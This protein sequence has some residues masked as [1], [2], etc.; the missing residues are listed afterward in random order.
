MSRQSLSLD[1]L[2]TARLKRVG[3]LVGAISTI[4]C[5]LPLRI[6]AAPAATSTTLTVSSGS[7]RVASV[8]A[9]SVITLTATVKA[10]STALTTGQVNF[11]DAAAKRCT[12]IHLLGTAQLTK[13]GTAVMKFR[14]GLGSYSYEAEFLGTRSDAASTSSASA[15]VVTGKH[16]TATKMTA[17]G[18][19]DAIYTLA[20]TVTGSPAKSGVAAPTGKVSFVDASN[21]NAVLATAT[22]SPGTAGPQ[23]V[24]TQSP[25]AGD[26]PFTV[27]TGDFNGDGI[28]DL[29]VGDAN[30][31]TIV[32]LL[33]NGD[34]TF[35][36]APEITLAS[37]NY[38][39]FI[40]VGDFNGDGIP[41]LAIV[42]TGNLDGTFSYLAIL[43]GNGDGTFKVGATP[44]VGADAQS[45]TVGD[46]NGDGT[47][48]LAVTNY[49]NNNLTIL[50]GN[51]DGT[52]TAA[53]VNPVTGAN[54][55]FAAAGD[56]NGD[57]KLDLAVANSGGDTLT[58]L[59]GNG[60]GTFKTAASPATGSG[61]A[62][63][64]VADFNGDGILDLAVP[65]Y[66]G[67]TVTIL[68]G[69]GD[70]TFTTVGNP[71]AGSGPAYIAAGDFNGDGIPDL[72]VANVNGNTA[73]IFLGKGDGTFPTTMT[74]KTGNGPD[75]LA[76]ADFN[77]DGLS[78][79]AIANFNSASLSIF[80]Q[81][82]EPSTA[83]ASGVSV[84]GHGTFQIE[85]S[86]GGDG[87]YGS[88]VSGSTTLFD[89]P[90]ATVTTLTANASGTEVKEVNA[91]TAVTLIAAVK[92]G[93]NRVA[94]GQV[95][96]CDASAPYCTDIHL[97]GVAPLTGA[98]T[99]SMT[100]VPGIG[101]HSYKAVFAGIT[102]DLAA[103]ASSAWP[104]T[105][106]GKFATKT[107]FAK[108][109][110]AGNYTLTAFVNGFADAAGAASPT[111]TVRFLDTTNN[112]ALLG[113]ATLAAGSSALGF[114]SPNPV[115]LGYRPNAIAVADFN[116]DG[117]LDAVVGDWSTL[118]SP[119]LT[120][121]L[122]N[123]DGTF[124]PVQQTV[125]I[126]SYA[127]SIVAGDF[128]GDGI[129]DLAVADGI[130]SITIL[131]GNGNGTFT[132]VAS[133]S[134]GVNPLSIVAADF[135]GDG[136]LDLA[137]ANAGDEGDPASFTV[138]LGNGDGT[139]HAQTY[140]VSDISPLYLAV[141]DFN[142]DG[143]PDLVFTGSNSTYVVDLLGKGDGTFPSGYLIETGEVPL[144]IAVAD[145]NQDGKPDL[146]VG[147]S[148]NQNNGTPGNV[149]IFLGYGDGTFTAA[150]SSPAAGVVY[151]A[152][153][154]FNGDGIP[155]LAALEQSNGSTV[156]VLLGKGDGTFT[157]APSPAS[158]SPLAYQLAVG[159]FN[160]DG[161]PDVALADYA[162]DTL[163]TFLTQLKHISTAKITGVALE[164]PV[165]HVVEAS[166]GGDSVFN[167]SISGTAALPPL[168]PTPVFSLPAGVYTST[169]KV[170]LS[171]SVA[172][173]AFYYTTDGKTNPTTASKKYSA[174]FTVASTE[175]IKAIAV[176]PGY[177]ESAVATAAYEINPPAAEPAFQ[178]AGATYTTVQSVK[179]SDATPGVTIYYTTN[180]VTIP[181]SSTGIK[182]T[183]PIAVDVSETIMAMAMG[184]DN[185]AS[186]VSKATYTLN[187]PPAAKPA[188]KPGTGTYTS[189]Q[190]VSLSDATSG[191]V[192][193]YTT[194]GKTAPSATTGF[195]YTGPIPVSGTETILATA[196]GTG[197]SQSPVAS[198]TYTIPAADQA[199]TIQFVSPIST[200][201]TQTIAIVGSGF[202]KQPAFSGNSPDINFVD[203][204]SWSAGTGGDLIGLSISSWTE[205]QI[206]ISGFT[207]GYGFFGSLNNGDEVTISVWNVQN[208]AGPAV[209]ANI[210]VGGKAKA[211]SSGASTDR[212]AIMRR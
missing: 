129:P 45:A 156:T 92:A 138:M 163:D 22:L 95:S 66:Y 109:G 202:G 184:P 24:H 79:L 175:T 148:E 61:P 31:D 46:F 64:A 75:A 80:T 33:G 178:P 205:T 108:S 204:T 115:Q 78:D 74:L 161:I 2:C 208:G 26:S 19:S 58:I 91:G 12:D 126:G 169:Q 186:P 40:A 153:G 3:F 141:G 70:G 111:G 1:V 77:G 114:L 143:F 29:A 89:A 172:G 84:V 88:S 15:L 131:L 121:L 124:T 101:A 211:C 123:G 146:A 212:A 85:A 136:K 57:G 28:P 49:S 206:V 37:H 18:D 11:C 177:S 135:N 7:A 97:L 106:T 32:I 36:D 173:A 132:A 62:A 72:A 112:N 171:D 110:S 90:P 152:S 117:K 154:D 196:V 162:N 193:Y 34:G 158:T 164:G 48:D 53:A 120:T 30:G 160:D 50:L 63:I 100:L 180:G 165:A 130:N 142:G 128:N 39:N 98:G 8:E 16:P 59:L 69:K 166:Y 197:W 99:A 200:A 102:H 44:E 181:T 198:A 103:S 116:G 168:T 151:I 60:D 190:S 38:T 192:I 182:Y 71:V 195:K 209:C 189:A 25:P 203:G 54:P 73:L 67:G 157:A 191:A 188:F 145:F 93:G 144:S 94:A 118:Y 127:T 122:G 76:V 9:G 83:M 42:P 185:S 150:G 140:Y 149:S 56:F 159:D 174:P 155:D 119:S 125:A 41:D 6:C 210:T 139:F 13:A 113:A 81:W 187:L 4:L 199:P 65:D 183:A 52:F 35:R 68:Q 82:A 27:A 107:S 201:Q 134:T 96:F 55:Y 51:G 137:T 207:G 21:G 176:A 17:Q 147:L 47:L 14:P 167:P 194:D 5:G 23:W 133:P 170:Q 86:Y 104:L 43:L 87:N 179:L 20:A 105:V 10:G